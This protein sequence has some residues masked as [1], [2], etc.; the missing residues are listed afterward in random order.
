ML[1]AASTHHV[2]VFYLLH[3]QQRDIETAQSPLLQ[4]GSNSSQTDHTETS[5]ELGVEPDLLPPS[6]KR[7]QE[8]QTDIALAEASAI[9]EALV[10]E[11]TPVASENNLQSKSR[12]NKTPWTFERRL[13]KYV[14]SSRV[15]CFVCRASAFPRRSVWTRVLSCGVDRSYA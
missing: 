5:T 12:A 15:V 13:I 8:S 11:S 1:C 2:S 7:E 9:A 14:A 10:I 4:Q 3:T 6:P